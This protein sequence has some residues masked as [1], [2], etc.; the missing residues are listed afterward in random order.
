MFFGPLH[1][2]FVYALKPFIS[3]VKSDEAVFEETRRRTS[4]V[5]LGQ[6]QAA[7]DA[8]DRDQITAEVYARK[9]QKKRFSDAFNLVFWCTFWVLL[10]AY[11][12]I[13]THYHFSLWD[14]LFPCNAACQA[15]Q[16]ELDR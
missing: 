6:R 15:A 3:T 16:A 2:P 5:P 9:N 10:I 4:E 7:I 12:V 11:W 8:L 14:H 1:F 13:T